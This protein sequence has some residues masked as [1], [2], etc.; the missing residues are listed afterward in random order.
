M[1]ARARLAG[2]LPGDAPV[3]GIDPLAEDLCDRWFNGDP[4]NPASVLVIGIMKVRNFTLVRDEDG[5][6]RIPTMEL[7]RVE[8]LGVLGQSPLGGRLPVA[9]S[10]DQQML[11]DANEERTGMSPLPIDAETELDKHTVLGED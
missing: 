1:S 7:T 5:L 9:S 4:E 6:R 8:A 2:K 11:L 3:N 10:A